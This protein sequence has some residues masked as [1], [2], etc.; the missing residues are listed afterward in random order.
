VAGK[1]RQIVIVAGMLARVRLV[2]LVERAGGACS[3]F[4]GI[5]LV[6]R[7]WR[8]GTDEEG[9]GLMRKPRPRIITRPDLMVGLPTIEGTRITVEFVLEEL[10]GGRTIEQLIDA[11][12][13]LTREEIEA[14]L[15]YAA[16]TVHSIS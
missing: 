5:L 16:D 2:I 13:P 11:Y 4:H 14:A 1:E 9:A 8:L 12:P 15:E 10:A 7:E 3:G 6:K